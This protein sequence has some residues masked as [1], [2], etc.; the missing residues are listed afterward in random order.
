[1]RLVLPESECPT[2]EIAGI[3]RSSFLPL[4]TIIPD[5]EVRVILRRGTVDDEKGRT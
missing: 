5:T 2:M 4:R 1:M 3:I